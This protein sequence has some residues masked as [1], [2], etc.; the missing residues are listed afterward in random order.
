MLLVQKRNTH[1]GFLSME[2][3]KFDVPPPS[4]ADFFPFFFLLLPLKKRRPRIQFRKKS[5]L[6]QLSKSLP[7]SCRCLIVLVFFFNS[8]LRFFY[9]YFVLTD[10]QGGVDIKKIYRYFLD[11]KILGAKQ[12]QSHKTKGKQKKKNVKYYRRRMIQRG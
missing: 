5:Q 9:Y 3:F 4:M 11:I 7:C 8:P 10:Q 12:Q 1:L 6:F 2:K